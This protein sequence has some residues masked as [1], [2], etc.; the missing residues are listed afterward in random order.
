MKK[1]PIIA[2]LLLVIGGG[3]YALST[4]SNQKTGSDV[5]SEE[6]AD[7]DTLTISTSF[8]PLEFA[9]TEIVGDLGV[10]TNIASGVDPHDFRPSA[11]DI[12]TLQ[13]SDLVVLHGAELEP[14][15]EDVKSQ[16]VQA[17]IP[18]VLA[19]EGLDLIEAGEHTKKNITKKNLMKKNLMTSTHMDYTILTHGLTQFYLHKQLIL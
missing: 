19:T 2:I 11:Q 12:L 1:L 17:G 13:R 9:L 5:V 18:V 6:T 16:L 14:W 15:G 7:N 4:I 8:Y 3:L 10:V